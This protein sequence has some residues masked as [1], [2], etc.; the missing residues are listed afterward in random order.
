MPFWHGSE[1]IEF[2]SKFEMQEPPVIRSHI[3]MKYASERSD[4]TA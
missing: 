2:A 1:L 4:E 3:D